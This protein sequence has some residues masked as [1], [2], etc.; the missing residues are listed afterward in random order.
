MER[1]LL[2]R[3][4][5]RLSAVGAAASASGCQAVV[6]SEQTE[7]KH[8]EGT[9]VSLDGES[10]EGATVEVIAGGGEVLSEET[11]DEDGG[12]RAGTD[13]GAVWLRAE[14]SG[15]LTR[16]VA[17]AP[18]SSSRIR[19]TPREGTVSLSFGG[20]VM[21]GQ[22]FYD[23]SESSGYPWFRIHES[24][25]EKDHEEILSHIQP[26]LSTADMTSV[27]LETTLTTT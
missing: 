23:D 24:E 17:A 11:T 27:N 2:R 22:R 18:D 6:S 5:L 26:L 14:A 20:D 1:E 7:P 21:F 19:L 15:F 10:V 9:V 4:F 12:F 16:T 13:A 3:D 8:I 25:R